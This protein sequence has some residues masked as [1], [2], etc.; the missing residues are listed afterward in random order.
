[1]SDISLCL[2]PCATTSAENSDYFCAVSDVQSPSW[3]MPGATA[4]LKERL[5]VVSSE[6]ATA[7][8]AALQKYLA[9]LGTIH[10]RIVGGVEDAQAARDAMAHEHGIMEA[11]TA[12]ALTS[13]SMQGLGASALTC[14]PLHALAVASIAL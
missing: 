3:P 11:Y 13:L 9:R 5:V 7:S 4:T 12:P 10:S 8:R 6:K 1:V 2:Y 14:R